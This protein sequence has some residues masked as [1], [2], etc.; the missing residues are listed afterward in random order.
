MDRTELSSAIRQEM[1]VLVGEALEAVAPEMLT[2]NLATLEQRVQQVGRVI[3]GGL[4]ERVATAQAPGLP[5]PARC[6]A[7]H[8]ALKRRERPLVGLV[9]DYTLRRPYYWC[10]AC[11]RGAAPLDTA[12]GPGPWRR[13][14]GVDAGG[15]TGGGGR[16][17]H[18]GG[19]TGTGSPG[20]HAQ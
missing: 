14:A 15:G 3:L 16:D 17:L 18:A 2:A 5:R 20:R 13:V 10:A 4:I 1:Q 6:P 8:G 7:C 11:T 12:L 9:G 19:G